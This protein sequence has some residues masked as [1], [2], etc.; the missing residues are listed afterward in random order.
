MRESAVF[1]AAGLGNDRW[2]S[3]FIPPSQGKKFLNKRKKRR[4]TRQTF[5]GQKGRLFSK[6][7][8]DC[9]KH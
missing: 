1:T 5:L 8:T 7:D 6:I 3:L 9:G 2:P 4:K